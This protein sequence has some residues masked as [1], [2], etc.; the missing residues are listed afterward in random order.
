MRERKLQAD[1]QRILLTMNSSELDCF[2]R[3]G[4]SSPYVPFETKKGNTVRRKC[5]LR[6]E[7]AGL[8]EVRL[9]EVVFHESFSEDWMGMF[10]PNFK[11][12]TRRILV[13][14]IQNKSTQH[15]AY[16]F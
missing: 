4:G 10:P 12:K 2:K 6:D 7:F 14:D 8:T 9:G 1:S 15:K 13:D 16:N 5:S 11:S 3:S